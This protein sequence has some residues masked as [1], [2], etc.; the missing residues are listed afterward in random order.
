MTSIQ[1]ANIAGIAISCIK[2]R[3]IENLYSYELSQYILM[4]GSKDE[5]HISVFDYSRG[6][7]I[8]GKCTNQNNYSFYDYGESAYISLSINGNSFKG[9]DY[10]SG[11]Y[12]SG[13]IN[14]NSVSLYDYQTGEYYNF[15]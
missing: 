6:C 14:G 11:S 4:S 15:M 2:N 1:R 10:G 9:Y 13:S 8:I 7:Y 3:D 12:Y 5:K